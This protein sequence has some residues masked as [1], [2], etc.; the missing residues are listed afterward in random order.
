MMLESKR[1]VILPLRPHVSV[2]RFFRGLER[3]K[4]H[5]FPVVPN[6]SLPLSGPEIPSAHES[7][8]AVA[9][10]LPLVVAVLLR[11]NVPEIAQPVVRRVAVDVVDVAARPV[12]VDVKPSKPVFTVLPPQQAY[13]SV[14]LRQRDKS[15]LPP[16]DG[17]LIARDTVR[18]NAGVGVVMQNFFQV[19]LRDCRFGFS[20]IIAPYKQWFGMGADVADNYIGPRLIIRG[21]R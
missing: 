3:P 21:I 18:K 4:V 19:V 20:H 13:G 14:A 11:R 2:M 9:S 6:G 10:R 1:R 17:K 12:A 5:V 8:S 16:R 15:S 7:G